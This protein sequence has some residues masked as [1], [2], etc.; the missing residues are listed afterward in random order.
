MPTS[1]TTTT[2]PPATTTTTTTTTTLPPNAAAAFGLTQ[3]VFGESSF[4][5]VTNWGN[6][7]GNLEGQWLCQFPSY[8][9][10]PDIELGPG[11]QALIGLAGTPPPDLAGMVVTVDLGPAIGN[12]DANSGEVAL[13]ADSSFDDPESMVA[14]VEW[15]EPGH[16]RAEVAIAAGLWTGGAVAVFDDA[17]SISTGVFPSISEADWAA[18]VGG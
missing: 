16:A 3:V 15:G 9:S 5:V 13:Y 10:L 11:E 17:P 7:R 12:F 14:Y 2:V 18:D 4:V 6:D 8:I 1:S